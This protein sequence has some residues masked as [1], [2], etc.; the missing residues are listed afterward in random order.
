MHRKKRINQKESPF[1]DLSVLLQVALPASEPALGSEHQFQIYDIQL[2]EEYLAFMDLS[3]S[4]CNIQL[5]DK[6]GE[7]LHTSR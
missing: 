7:F 1:L 5:L 3:L 6:N 4:S 2:N